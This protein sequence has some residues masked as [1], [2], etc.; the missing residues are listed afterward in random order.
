VA[1]EGWPY[2]LN[3]LAGQAGPGDSDGRPDD[4]WNFCG[5]T[6][7]AAVCQWALNWS[8]QPDA[9]SDL[10]Y[11]DGHTGYSFMSD[12]AG[13]LTT[14]ARI[15]NELSSNV[16]NPEPIIRQALDRGW[17]V[18]VLTREPAGYNPIVKYTQ[19]QPFNHICPCTGYTDTHVI[20]HQVL[21]GYQEQLT[22]AEFRKRSLGWVLVVKTNPT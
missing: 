19:Q 12:L 1:L 9:I 18:I 21:G 8:L 13:F 17:P 6:S 11:G 3:Q 4:A 5:Q 16:T 7:L 22:W 15:A 10:I 20:R 2:H 14:H